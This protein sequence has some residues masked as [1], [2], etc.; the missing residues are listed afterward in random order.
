MI[1]S[2]AVEIMK[3][4]IVFENNPVVKE[5]MTK[6]VESMEIQLKLINF[7]EHLEIVPDDTVYYA[8][9]IHE[10]L[11]EEVFLLLT[12][13]LCFLIIMVTRLIF[14]HQSEKN[15]RLP[16]GIKM[17]L[18]RQRFLRLLQR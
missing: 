11:L 16:A 12:V 9:E 10:I 18:T 7:S 15:L 8:S 4:R 6:A 3:N 1:L 14:L 17:L 2:E 13:I 5:A